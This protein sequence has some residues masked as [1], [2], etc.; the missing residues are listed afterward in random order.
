V[1]WTRARVWT[2]ALEAFELAAGTV[3]ELADIAEPLGVRLALEA[4]VEVTNLFENIGDLLRLMEVG[5]LDARTAGVLNDTL[6]LPY[7]NDDMGAAVVEAGAHLVHV[8][9][10]DR[11]ADAP[12]TQSDF[13]S[14][15][16][17]LERAGYHGWYTVEFA[18]G[19]REA[20][21]DG[22]GRAGLRC[23]K[24]MLPDLA[25]AHVRHSGVVV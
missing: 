7:R 19:R 15:V 10:Q 2:E 20:D 12:R 25:A 11:D 23:L 1:A 14:F 17:D 6:Q 18:Y 16:A 4:P 22:V 21:P 5:G 3:R 9:L 13:T 24:A 8:H